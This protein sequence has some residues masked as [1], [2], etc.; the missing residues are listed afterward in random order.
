MSACR[1]ARRVA[2]PISRYSACAGAVVELALATKVSHYSCAPFWPGSALRLV[3]R[4]SVRAVATPAG[5]TPVGVRV[6]REEG[7]ACRTAWWRVL[8]RPGLTVMSLATKGKNSE[9][10]G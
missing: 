8:R 7:G 4:V 9:V 3:G 5:C 2:L 10:V 6:G 1:L